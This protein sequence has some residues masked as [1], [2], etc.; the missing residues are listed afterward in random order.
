MLDSGIFLS[1]LKGWLTF[2]QVCRKHKAMERILLMSVMPDIYLL[3]RGDHLDIY[4]E[5]VIIDRLG[6]P[7]S[8]LCIGQVMFL[9]SVPL[10]A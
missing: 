5:E 9:L 8:S 3:L 1:K 4:V 7:K 2:D 6:M 10:Q